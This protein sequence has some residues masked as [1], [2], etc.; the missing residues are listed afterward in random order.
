MIGNGMLHAQL[1][2][3]LSLLFHGDHES[4][5]QPGIQGGIVEFLSGITSVAALQNLQYGS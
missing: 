1:Q 3:A 4:L 2:S 5:S